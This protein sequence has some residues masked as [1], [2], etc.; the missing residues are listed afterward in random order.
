VAKQ[1]PLAF[2]DITAG[3]WRYLTNRFPPD[4]VAERQARLFER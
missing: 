1:S 2:D 3:E 4:E